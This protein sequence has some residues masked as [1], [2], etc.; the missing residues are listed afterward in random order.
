VVE[1]IHAVL[2]GAWRQ[3]YWICTPAVV[4]PF[5]AFF[6]AM[7]L[8]QRYDTQTKILI[9]ETAK[10]NPF[11]E[12]LAVSTNL[13]DRMAA[14]NALL[15]SRHVLMG[16]ASDLKWID[17]KTPI[18]E[19]DRL[20]DRL[21][22]ELNARLVGED[23]VEISYR[24]HEPDEMAKTLETVSAR[25]IEYIIAPGK[26][27]IQGSESFLAQELD[28][29]RKDLDAAE[30]IM[31]K[32][33]TEHA[34]ELPELHATNVA[35]LTKMREDLA[36]RETGLAGARAAFEKLKS[37][38]AQ[39]NPVVGRLEEQIVAT[40]SDLAIL[41]SRYT[42]EHSLVI[43]AKRKLQRLEEERAHLIKASKE[44][45][46]DSMERLWN[47]ASSTSNNTT[48]NGQTLL[49]SQL[50]EL[51]SAE[52][53]VKSLEHEVKNTRKELV[54][55]EQRVADFGVNEQ[56]LNELERD[57]KVKRSTYEN[58]LSR[59][60]NARVTGELGRFELPERVKVIDPPYTPGGPSNPPAM[61]FAIG[62]LGGG[63]VF[64]F[65]FAVARELMD[66]TIRRREALEKMLNVTVLCR[67][68]ILVSNNPVEPRVPPGGFNNT[69]G[70]L[71]QLHA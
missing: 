63:V 62:G 15:H 2:A 49:V 37:Q 32:Y 1:N 68:P 33:K 8:P 5:L 12:D 16:V 9:Q 46:T 64:G 42:D 57:L 48:E 52:T 13:K 41:R 69:G 44:L 29:R 36:E 53:K 17:E 70:S 40:L 67:I 59:Y 10:L 61:L 20:I 34:S 3:R 21:S 14:L 19:K 24:H 71:R 6:I 28:K 47:L 56:K 50:R 66:T 39:T 35:R 43:S 65:I 45:N 26:S 51:Q 18:K 54:E 11:L 60:E 22:V 58:L 23:L 30:R 31:A 4:L 38:L 27:S 25:F 55:L 7:L